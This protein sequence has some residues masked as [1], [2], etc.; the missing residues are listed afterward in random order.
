[1][2]GW[3]ARMDWATHWADLQAF[4]AELKRDN[5]VVAATLFTC[6]PNN[7][8]VYFEYDQGQAETIGKARLGEAFPGR[9]A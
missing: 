7:D 9:A 2:D 8:W 3:R 5:Y 1:M 4:D 6:A